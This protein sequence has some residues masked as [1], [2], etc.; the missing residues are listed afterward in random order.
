[1]TV[2]C[3]RST[4][5]RTGDALGEQHELVRDRGGQIAPGRAGEPPIDRALEH[6]DGDGPEEVAA[7]VGVGEP[8]PHG[9]RGGDRGGVVVAVGLLAPRRTIDDVTAFW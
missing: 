4:G 3:Q 6:D 1:M 2:D 7:G 8:P 9:D 5:S